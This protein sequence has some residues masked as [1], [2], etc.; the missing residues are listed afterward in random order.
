MGGAFPG[1][2]KHNTSTKMDNLGQC[3]TVHDPLG[4][5]YLWMYVKATAAVT[6]TNMVICETAEE[7]VADITSAVNT[8]D[9]ASGVY[10][11]I[12]DSGET[13]TVN[14]HVGAFMYIAGGTG[15]GQM[16]RIVAN[17]ATTVWFRALYPQMDETDVLSTAASTDS[18]IVILNPWHIKT[19]ADADQQCVVGQA[20][21]AFT[22]GY[23][24]YI[25]VPHIWQVM[26]VKSAGSFTIGEYAIA[27]D[28]T[29][30]QLGPASDGDNETYCG[31]ALHAGATDQAS[32]FFL[33][34]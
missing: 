14:E 8:G 3:Y 1:A 29:A 25:L 30:G 20:P 7:T 6:A 24:G 28:D 17:S 26:L 32:P 22:S 15:A 4:G 27:T 21:I 2:K 31:I 16:R 9:R 10:P 19:A 12:T 11:S 23:Y 33:G 13:W 18:D 34:V 5:D